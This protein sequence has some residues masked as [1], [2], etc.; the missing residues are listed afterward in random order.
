MKKLFTPALLLGL[1]ILARAQVP[2]IITYQGR[3]TANG[4]N[5]SGTGNFKFAL[6]NGVNGPSLWSNNGTSVNGSEPAARVAVSVADGL[7]TVPLGDTTLAGMTIPIPA[8]AFTNGDVRLRL[9]FSAGEPAFTQL[10]PDQR[11]TSSGYAFLAAN[12]PDGAITS[13]S[14]ADHSVTGDK[15]HPFLDLGD[16]STAGRLR[17]FT[18]GVGTSGVTLQNGAMTTFG[19]DGLQRVLLTAGA[20]GT[21]GELRL[22]DNGGND[23]TAL[24]TATP[25][26]G[27]V[28]RLN[29]SEGRER[30]TLEA[31]GSRSAGHLELWSSNNIRRAHFYADAPDLANANLG[32]GGAG[33]D[34]LGA[35]NT[36]SIKL[37]GTDSLLQMFDGSQTLKAEVS[38]VTGTFRGVGG[39]TFYENIG[40]PPW[41][42]LARNND[43]GQFTLRTLGGG[44]RSQLGVSKG[45]FLSLFQESG[46]FGTILDGDNTGG[47]SGGKITLYQ[48]DGDF[49]LFLTGDSGGSGLVDV[50]ST[51]GFTR[52]RVDGSSTNDSG[53]ISVFDDNGTETIELLGA[54]SAA[55]GGQIIMRGNGGTPTV[56][57]EAESGANQG[58]QLTLRNGSGD[59]TVILDADALDNSGSLALGNGA[60]NYGVF[61]DGG[62][63]GFGRIQVRNTT[64]NTRVQI[65]GE[66]DGSGGEILVHDASGT[67]TVKLSGAQTST[68]GG[69]LELSQAD[70]AL[71]VILDGEVGTGGGGYLQLRNG[72]GTGTIT[73]DSD[74]SGEGRI[75]TQVLQITG[76]S[77]LSE[78]FDVRSAHEAPQPGMIVCID[79]KHPGELAVSA[80][81]YDRTVAGVMS[82]AGGVKPGMLMR[83]AGSKADGQHPV[84]LTGRVYCLVDARHGA[85]EPGDLITTSDTPGHGMK[86][87]DHARAQGAIIGKAMTALGDGQGLVLVLVSLQ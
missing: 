8:A 84:A 9:W 39:A 53:E 32:T 44:T 61:V 50:R 27:G 26:S 49:G 35:V 18:T 22:Y 46:G 66:G 86:A 75:T 12:V 59:S 56:L 62:Y 68:S 55:S 30:V 69:R 87:A 19:A 76:G 10:A 29:D 81:A 42:A 58:A 74:F 47:N 72:T 11:I 34:L 73:L 52:V 40:G 28:L 4:T 13:A 57:L 21:H 85:I 15:I 1:A 31:E 65:D 79:P 25:A 7:F 5:F 82:G 17:V 80:R 3:V 33:L 54:S 77:D 43:G 83:Q 71:T 48:G 41:A 51:N 63:T 20:L 24:L 37:R 6:L 67:A 45:G 23:Y 2:G 16:A 78:Q 60:G 38:G 64:G 36:G 70:G 14:L